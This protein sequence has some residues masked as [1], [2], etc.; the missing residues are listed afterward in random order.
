MCSKWTEPRAGSR[1]D[2][3]PGSLPRPPARRPATAKGPRVVENKKIFF[4]LDL[5]GGLQEHGGA[6]RERGAE[7]LS[8]P[9]GSPRVRVARLDIL[10]PTAADLEPGCT[11]QP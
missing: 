11:S 3:G 9:S 5:K 6:R 8:P 1:G 2:G 10:Y 7:G 4:P